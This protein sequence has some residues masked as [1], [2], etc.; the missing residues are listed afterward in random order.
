MLNKL[1]ATPRPI[2]HLLMLAL[3][4]VV[5]SWELFQIES[6]QGLSAFNF[7]FLIISFGLLFLIGVFLDFK[8]E[9]TGSNNYYGFFAGISFMLFSASVFHPSI[10][11]GYFL[12]LLGIR[13][14]LSLRSG[15][16]PQQKLF[17]AG[18]WIALAAII[19]PQ[20]VLFFAVCLLA[21][22]AHF[23]GKIYYYFIPIIGMIVVFMLWLGYK[24]LIEA[25]SIENLAQSLKAFKELS[26]YQIPNQRSWQIYIGIGLVFGVFYLMELR[27]LLRKN[28]PTHWLVFFIWVVSVVKVF[29]S[30]PMNEA[31]GL[32]L[33]F[34]T[35]VFVAHKLQAL[36][37]KIFI[38]LVLWVLLLV[39]V[40]L[41][42][43][44]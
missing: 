36:R 23:S 12:V 38:E 40:V 28:R 14:L 35:A 33:I 43:S 7:T 16:Y 19:E 11:L 29:A 17:D 41:K 2:N 3:L 37:K 13:R 18:F 34:P 30:T 42:I 22:L 15:I 8:N 39:M 6:K 27:D 10:V 4:L 25:G 32:F 44:S 21:V 31:Q 9:L 20:N 26:L 5:L 24:V 1:F